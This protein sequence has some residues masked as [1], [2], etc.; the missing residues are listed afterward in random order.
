MTSITFGGGPT[1]EAR[2]AFSNLKPGSQVPG[3]LGYIHQLKFNNGHTYGDQTHLLAT[4][5]SKTSIDGFKKTPVPVSSDE[6]VPFR[7]IQASLSNELPKPNGVN[8]LT[9]SMVP[10]YTGYVPNRKFRFSNTYRNECDQSIDAFLTERKTNDDKR[11]SLIS[12]VQSQRTHVPI[13]T[14]ADLR[15][16]LDTVDYV[17]HIC[18]ILILLLD[19]TIYVFVI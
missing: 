13:S 2:R 17:K 19:N 10:G 16:K 15:E 14:G 12:T 7:S 6:P 5:R 8:K 4:Q 18:M 1:L 3:Y 11:N 9:E